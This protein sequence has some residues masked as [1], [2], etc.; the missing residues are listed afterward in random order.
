[1]EGQVLARAVRRAEIDDARRF[2]L[3]NIVTT[4]AR[5]KPEEE[6]RFEA[7]L[8]RDRNKEVRDM[9]ITWED[10]LAESKTEGIQVGIQ[11]GEALVLK[12]QLGR[13]YWPTLGF[14]VLQFLLNRVGVK[15]D[16]AVMILLKF[17]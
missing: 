12:R 10:A 15:F 7:E 5:L 16:P 6:R 2:V 13:R 9:V 17:A 8:E 4:Y 11:Q 1:M 3:Y 14:V